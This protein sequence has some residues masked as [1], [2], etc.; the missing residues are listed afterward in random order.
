[1]KKNGNNYN[2]AALLTIKGI[3]NPIAFDAS[4]DMVGKGFS[5]NAKIVIDRTKWDVKYGSGSFFENLGDKMIL[6]E[7]SFEVS[8]KSLN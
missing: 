7:I 5:A 3:T 4:F 6:D 8:L 2:I 1:M